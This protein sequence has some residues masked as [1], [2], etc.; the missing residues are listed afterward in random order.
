MKIYPLSPKQIESAVRVAGCDFF[1]IY[2]PE[3][4]PEEPGLS[5]DI[6]KGEA[7]VS[8]VPYALMQGPRGLKEMAWISDNLLGH[9]GI[10]RTLDVMDLSDDQVSTIADTIIDFWNQDWDEANVEEARL[11]HEHAMS[12]SDDDWDPE[13]D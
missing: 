1:R 10:K 3:F 7:V 4:G 11:A 12:D 13:D 8:F 5:V 6:R 2:T 9:F